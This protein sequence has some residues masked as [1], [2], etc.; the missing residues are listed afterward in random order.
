MTSTNKVNQQPDLQT[1]YDR[2]AQDMQNGNTQAADQTIKRAARAY[3]Q[4]NPGATVQDFEKA[5][6]Q[7]ESGKVSSAAINNVVNQVLP[8]GDDASSPAS[9]LAPQ[10]AHSHQKA[11]GGGGGGSDTSASTSTVFDPT[12]NQYVQQ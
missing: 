5:F 1:L 3:A 9:V 2:A 7:A 6:A 12:T 4:Q 11:G 8:A 10:G